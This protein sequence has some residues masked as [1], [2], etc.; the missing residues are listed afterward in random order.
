MARRE[1]RVG[2]VQTA[3]ICGV[4]ALPVTV[5]ISV[6]SG[7][8]G[9]HII[10]LADLAVKE[11]TRRVRQAIRASGFAI[12]ND[13]VVVNLAPSSLRKVGSGFDLP[14][15]LAY[16]L[17]TG[18]I[19]EVLVEGRICVGELSLGGAV[20][21]VSGQLAYE[22]L[23]A[24]L[25]L[26]LCT[27]PG[28]GGLTIQNELGHIC[29][30]NLVDLHQQGFGQPQAISWDD[31]GNG[32]DFADI[33]GNDFAKRAL[34]ISAAGG[35]ALLMIGPPGS[36]KSMMAAR[37]PTILPAL[38][39]SE[40]I[41]SAL[42]HSVAG[43]PYEGILAG[44]R[45]FRAPHHSASR[46]GLVG[47]GN[48]TSPGEVS[49]A[50]NGVLFLD[51]LP[52]FGLSVLQLLRQP[53]EQGFVA[54]ARASGTVIFPARFL[55]LAAANPC[56]CGYFGDDRRSCRCTPAQING[57]LGRIGGPLLDRIHMIVDVARAPAAEILATGQGMS[58]EQLRQGVLAAREFRRHRQ[59]SGQLGQLGSSGL[60]VLLDPSGQAR[61][62]VLPKLPGPVSPLRSPALLG[63]PTLLNPS[64]LDAADVCPCPSLSVAGAGSGPQAS[65]G[66]N[67][68]DSDD[69]S[70][71]LPESAQSVLRQGSGAALLADCRLRPADLCF[72]E[73]M[74]DHYRLSGRAIMSTLAVART[75][76]DMELSLAVNRDHLTEAIGY[77]PR[78]Q[79]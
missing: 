58:S 77:R 53:I 38:E 3:T 18:Q 44:C 22:Q 52:E 76:A 70:G 32:L 24:R 40:R 41:D 31:N 62:S 23:A 72:L 15:A 1:E 50:H 9:F 8:P 4:E 63:Q 2:F 68:S 49:L 35:H 19:P 51:E 14:I 20:K 21:T 37:M 11:A 33:A 26:G 67:S 17:A 56:P 6:G 5:E 69:C 27:G 57:Y 7:L 34:Q 30:E 36:G 54:L 12:R 42:I 39:D 61:P 55:L 28:P 13:Y 71:V 59:P 45:P 29:L 64:G 47:G 46:A 73:A 66:A 78:E 60:P 79:R 43:L 75:I 74:A 10:G 25:G 65:L 16:L 48:P